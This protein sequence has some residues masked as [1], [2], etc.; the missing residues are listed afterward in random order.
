MDATEQLQDDL[1]NGRIDAQRLV[2]L[3]LTLQRKLQ[4]AEQRI[5]ELERQ[6]PGAPP[7]KVAEPAGIYG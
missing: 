6:L 1:R 4:A 5:A 7:A 2:D 3:I